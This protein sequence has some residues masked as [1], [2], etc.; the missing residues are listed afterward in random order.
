MKLFSFPIQE[1]GFLL[2]VKNYGRCVRFYSKKLGLKVRYRKPYLTV[3]EFGGGYFLI[4]KGARRNKALRNG[5][6]R[7][8]VL[9]VPRAVKTFRKRGIRVRFH[10]YEW[11]DIGQFK[12]PDGNVVEFCR[13]K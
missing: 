2:N 1:T 10:S 13:W 4:E 9:D 11:G 3:F 7:L 5:V 12:D 6:I 8:N